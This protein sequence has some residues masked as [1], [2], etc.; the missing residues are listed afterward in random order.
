[1]LRTSQNH[2]DSCLEI[3]EHLLVCR[4][5]GAIDMKLGRGLDT[6]KKTLVF[7]GAESQS[8]AIIGNIDEWLLL[9]GSIVA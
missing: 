1:M 3:K 7:I 8:R 6:L 2:R 5:S 9:R 4:A